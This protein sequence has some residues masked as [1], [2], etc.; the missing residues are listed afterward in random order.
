MV[1]L[2]YLHQHHSQPLNPT[3]KVLKIPVSTQSDQLHDM[4][5]CA[6]LIPNLFAIPVPV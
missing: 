6:E 2:Q 3:L 1:I 4:Y 5:N